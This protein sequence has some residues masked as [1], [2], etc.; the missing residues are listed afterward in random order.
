MFHVQDPD[1][2][3]SEIKVLKAVIYSLG[4]GV[5]VADRHGEFI[6]FNRVAEEILGIGAVDGDLEHWS[7]V[8][9]C[10]RPDRVTLFPASDLPLARALGGECVAETEIFIRN[11]V[12]PK[13]VWISAKANPLW[14]K[15]GQLLGGVVV[16]QDVTSKKE[17]QERIQMLTRAVEQTADSILI[18]DR[19]GVIGYVN[20]A[21]EQTSGYTCEEVLGQTPRLLKSGK[22]SPDFY[23]G[24]WTQITSG[25]PFRE[26]L[27]DRKKSGELFLAE[28]TITPIKDPEG[29]ITHFV[30]VIKDVTEQREFEEQKFQMALARTVQQ[31]YYSVRP[32]QVTGFDIA[33]SAFPADST[34]GDY[35]D[36]ISLPD[37]CLGITVGD[38]SGHGF[39]SALL[40]AE[41]RASV[42]AS[43]LTIADPGEILNRVNVALVSD[44][45]KSDYATLIMCRL[46]PSQRSLV[47]AS[48]GHVSGYILKPD[49]AVKRVLESTGQ[50]LGMFANLEFTSSE[51]IP[52]ES[53]ET[54]V[55][56]TDGIT[57][58]E[59]SD[60]T[61]YGIDRALEYI[62]AHCSS[63]NAR[64]IVFG[65]VEAVREFMGKSPQHDDLTLVICKST[66]ERI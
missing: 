16:F 44:L 54:L 65:L 39:S 32:P 4:E 1:S 18:T 46:Y 58:A 35:F 27:T 11:R 49:G 8:Y 20:P 47:Y 42:R 7:D 55:L 31:R 3:L 10:Y 66:V 29:K 25:Q 12:R 40:M 56:L 13:G 6:Y 19:D 57:E 60:C 53:N 50:P 33:G 51:E 48:A 45:A 14:D 37:G 61:E 34:G 21:F 63:D 22:H 24:L 2:L 43:A 23:R 62:R 52:I 59:D 9:G 26:V 64:S 41:L 36:F 5:I 30:S 38:V 17:G 15:D 28:Q